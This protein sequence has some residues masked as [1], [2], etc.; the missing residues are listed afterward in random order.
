M[1]KSNDEIIIISSV[2][3]FSILVTI[4]KLFPSIKSKAGLRIYGSIDKGNVFKIK[5]D[6]AN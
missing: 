2:Y 3:T 4:N 6:D 5:I 1:T